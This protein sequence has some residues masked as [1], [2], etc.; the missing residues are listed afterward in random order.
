MLI[1]LKLAGSTWEAL[2]LVSAQSTFEEARTNP[3]GQKQDPLDVGGP[4][5]FQDV[6]F[7]CAV[8]TVGNLP[9]AGC[10]YVETVVDGLSGVAF[11]K[12]YPCRSAWNAADILSSRVL[13]YFQRQG[14]SVKE[15]HTRR[16]IEYCGFLPVHPFEALLSASHIQH[17]LLDRRDHPYFY[18]CEQFY[19]F[20]VKEF[21]QPA[22]RKKFQVSLEE[23]QRQLDMF[24]E[25]Y[26]A[27]IAKRSR[28]EASMPHV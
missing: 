6:F 13:P 25:A 1:P 24:L 8:K 14:T 27:M 5:L 4:S 28:S 17:L 22:L 23:L 7:F 9:G 11:A 3:A 19:W 18:L 10:I 15:I 20:L 16:T 21:L 26:N 2:P 12:V